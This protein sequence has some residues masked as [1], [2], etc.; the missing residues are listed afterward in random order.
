MLET[1]WHELFPQRHLCSCI[2][3]FRRLR[4][5]SCFPREHCTRLRSQ[6]SGACTSN[7]NIT[8]Q[9]AV[10]LRRGQMALC[11]PPATLA[12]GDNGAGVF[13]SCSCGRRYRSRRFWRHQ[14]WESA[15][16]VSTIG[17]PLGPSGIE[18][19]CFGV[20]GVDLGIQLVRRRPFGMPLNV[21][22]GGSPLRLGLSVKSFSDSKVQS[23]KHLAAN[24]TLKAARWLAERGSC[25]GTT[26]S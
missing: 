6:G 20:D 26:E 4:M 18:K 12:A 24:L 10:K 23:T 22:V 1:A 15:I 9:G 21:V 7:S 14:F 2:R 11:L 3:R 5:C 8:I 17:R 16:V 19:L 13:G 25:N